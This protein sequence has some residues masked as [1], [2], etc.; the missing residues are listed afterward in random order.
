MD[1]SCRS[2]QVSDE[3]YLQAYK[4]LIDQSNLETVLL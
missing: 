3:L 4:N 2:V 1:I